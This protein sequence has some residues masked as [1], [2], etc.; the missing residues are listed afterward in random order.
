M[1]NFFKKASPKKKSLFTNKKKS[2]RP[3]FHTLRVQDITRETSDCVSVAFEVPD[4]LADDYQFVPGQYLTL[5]ADV[6]GKKVRRS[7]SLCSS[8]ADGELRVLSALV[9]RK[10][11]GHRCAEN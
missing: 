10:R 7:Y 6:D 3:K 8:P 11:I 5:E 2:A 9:E 4:K 1:L